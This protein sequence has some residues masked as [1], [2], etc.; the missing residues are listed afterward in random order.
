MWC[1]LITSYHAYMLC[2]GPLLSSDLFNHI[3]DLCVFSYPDVCFLS[4]SVMFNILLYICVCVAA[5]LF[6]QGW[7]VPMFTCYKSLLEVRMN[8]RLVFS[9]SNVTLED[10]VMLG[11]CCPSSGDS[12]LKFLVLVF[13]SG[14]VSLTQI[15]VAKID[16]YYIRVSFFII[17]FVFDL[18]IFR[19]CCSL[20]SAN[21]FSS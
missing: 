11:K 12:S 9:C 20:L 17:T 7:W 15:D 21:S 19:P 4:W 10:V 14:V 3:C 16:I 2:P 5:S 8:F 18:F 1:P 13:I 6:L